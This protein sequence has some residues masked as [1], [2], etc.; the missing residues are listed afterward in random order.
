ML[1]CKQRPPR[2]FE[3]LKQFGN[4]HERRRGSCGDGRTSVRTC[5]RF[6]VMNATIKTPTWIQSQKQQVQKHGS[7]EEPLHAE[8]PRASPQQ[9]PVEEPEHGFKSAEYGSCKNT[10]PSDRRCSFVS[11]TTNACHLGELVLRRP[12]QWAES[13][14]WN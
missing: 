1:R 14:G 7:Q 12:P 6:T 8:R 13:S 3:Q 4:P 10:E 5:P 11:T 2:L 9:L